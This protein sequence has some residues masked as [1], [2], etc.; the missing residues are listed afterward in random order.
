MLLEVIKA[1]AQKHPKDAS[2]DVLLARMDIA[3]LAKERG[4]SKQ[5]ISSAWEPL[6]KRR[7]IRLL[8]PGSLSVRV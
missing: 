3:A 6:A 5:T 4:L 7:Y 2:G 8:E 1:E